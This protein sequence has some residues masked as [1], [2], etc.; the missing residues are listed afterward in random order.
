VGIAHIL[1]WSRSTAQPTKK[2][3]L[4][5]LGIEPVGFCAPVFPRYRHARGMNDVRLDTA[6]SEPAGQPEP[7]PAGL[8]GNRNTIDLVP[9]LLRLSSP[10]LEQL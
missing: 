1:Q 4:Q 3:A 5:A 2:R 8:Q 7:V 10:P 9:G 6:R